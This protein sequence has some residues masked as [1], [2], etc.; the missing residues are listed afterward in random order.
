MAWRMPSRRWWRAPRDLADE[1][2]GRPRCRC[3]RVQLARPSPTSRARKRVRVHER[4]VVGERDQ[5]VVDG[6]DVRLGRLPRGRRRRSWSSARDRRPRSPRAP[7]SGRFVE[8]LG[9]QAPGPSTPS[10][11][12]HRPRRCPR[13]PARGAAAPAGRSTSC[14]PRPRQGRTRRTRRIP[15]PG[16]RDALRAGRTCSCDLSCRVVDRVG[17]LGVHRVAASADPRGHAY[18]STE[19]NST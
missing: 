17:G 8:H 18:S 15:L 5:H 4:A 7:P 19:Q 16:G 3:R 14:G 10:P 6:R 1:L 13:F 11:S 2:R 12:R 9:D